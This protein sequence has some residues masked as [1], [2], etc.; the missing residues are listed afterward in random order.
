MVCVNLFIGR[1]YDKE[2]G[3]PITNEHTSLSDVHGNHTLP[4]S[5]FTYLV[6]IEEAGGTDLIGREYSFG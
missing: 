2:V 3:Y 1:V 4:P 5:N 6:V